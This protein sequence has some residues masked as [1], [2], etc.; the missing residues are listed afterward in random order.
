MRLLPRRLRPARVPRRGGRRGVALGRRGL[1]RD[2]SD[3]GCNLRRVVASRLE[4][5]LEARAADARISEGFR[6][7]QRLRLR[8]REAP[9][10]LLE[11]RLELRHVRR[12][13]RRVGSLR[14]EL[15][16]G[17][18]RRGRGC[19]PRL[20]ERHH[21]GR[22]LSQEGAQSVRILLALG[23]RLARAN[24]R[25]GGGDGLLL[26][27]LVPCGQ[28]GLA[29][30]DGLLQTALTHQV[31]LTLAEGAAALLQTGVRLLVRPAQRRHL[32]LQLLHDADT[33]LPS[34]RKLQLLDTQSQ[35]LAQ[36]RRRARVAAALL[37]LLRQ[38]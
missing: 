14:L 38:R 12:H 13:A 16:R 8:L 29:L 26:P 21:V 3:V 25:G 37:R 15:R 18:L 24:Q 34:R 28:F 36:R 23:R 30:Q 19:A 33:H 6:R 27:C 11:L 4:L 31:D 17:P 1:R 2:A 22:L 5:G 10:L 35:L 7:L 9:A 20:V 32:R